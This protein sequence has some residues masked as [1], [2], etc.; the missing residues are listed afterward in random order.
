M[1]T[2]HPSAKLKS[3]FSSKPY[4]GADPREAEFL[5]VGLDTSYAEQIEQSSIFPRVLEYHQ[6]GV[7]FW[8]R[9]RVH[10]PF[11]LP[12]YSGEDQ[13]RHTSFAR[14]GFKPEHAH[15]VS[16]VD[17][18]HV[19]TTGRSK[20]VPA[21][22]DWPHLHMLADVLLHGRAR[23]IFIPSGAERL[24]HASKGFTWLSQ[25]PTEYRGPLGVLYRR[26]DKRVYSHLSFSVFGKY[27]QRKADEALVIHGLLAD[28]S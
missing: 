26:G 14:V 7:A 8:R 23:H 2:A 16:L 12:E 10:H 22:L 21:D 5:F 3:L 19:P 27:E 20:L 18:L 15:R 9:H 13:F 28:A 17:L 11:L 1:Y 6:D 4:Q 25:M 24:M